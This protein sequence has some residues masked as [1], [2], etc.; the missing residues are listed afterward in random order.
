MQCFRTIMLTI[1]FIIYLISQFNS[2][3]CVLCGN[4]TSTPSQNEAL[5]AFD[6][7]ALL[8]LCERILPST[9][10]PA[11]TCLLLPP[12]CK[13]HPWARA[14][15]TMQAEW[16]SQPWDHSSPPH[17]E[18]LLFLAPCPLSLWSHVPKSATPSPVP[19][20]E[21]PCSLGFCEYWSSLARRPLVP[22]N[23]TMS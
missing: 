16:M 22:H 3:S 21:C 2:V 23:T 20:L 10:V 6:L 18:E 1:L 5:R 15:H 4:F 17:S 8:A 19:F 12:G 9:C 13:Y 7:H 11:S 14:T